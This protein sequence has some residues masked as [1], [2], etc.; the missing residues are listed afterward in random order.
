[1]ILKNLRVRES[2]LF[3]YVIGSADV[4]FS[5]V[6]ERT[7]YLRND[8]D[9][10]PV[11]RG[12]ICDLG[13]D[14]HAN[15]GQVLLEYAL[16][17]EGCQVQD[18]SSELLVCLGERLG[19]IFAKKLYQDQDLVNLPILER[20]CGAFDFILQS[21]DLEFRMV[22]TADGIRYDLNCC[23]LVETAQ[24]TG[25]LQGLV[26]ARRGFIAICES[27]LALLAPEWEMIRPKASQAN[28]PLREIV[29]HYSKE[30]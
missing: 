20:V 16:S 23:P 22:Q 30:S 18:K 1:M 17:C 3:T 9:L 25:L 2:S 21:M 27:M 29:L 26:T 13:P 15:L 7:L 10:G 6:N 4:W 14:C 8:P 24:Q 12:E 11:V 19:T 5:G 28:E